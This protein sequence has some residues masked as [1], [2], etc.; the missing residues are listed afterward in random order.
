MNFK[1][2]MAAGAGLVF[3]ACAAQGM[4][5]RELRALEKS[6]KRHGGEY[7]QYYLIGALEGA[8]EASAQSVRVGSKA[9][10]CLNG[11]RLE[12]RTARSLFDVELKRHA[13][14]YE[15][16]MPVELVMVNALT[17]AYSC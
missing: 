12:P 14:L 2:M 13:D 5:I 9:L 1:R 7:V 8:M 6:D 3:F 15:A 4:S 17:T 16:D 11:R 10:I